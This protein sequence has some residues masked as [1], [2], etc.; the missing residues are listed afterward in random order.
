MKYPVEDCIIQFLA[1][2]ESPEDVQSLKKWL[3]IDPAHRDDLK[4]WLAAW[5]ISGMAYAI[6]KLNPDEAYQRFIFSN[7]NYGLSD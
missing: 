3:S 2:K 6:E 5:D 4:Q 7:K 1:R